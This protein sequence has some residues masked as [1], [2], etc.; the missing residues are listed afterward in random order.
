MTIVVLDTNVILAALISQK[1]SS[2]RLLELGASGKLEIFSSPELIAELMRVLLNELKSDRQEADAAVQKLLLFVK[3][4]VPKTRI[5]AVD[6][7]PDDNK[8]LECAASVDAEFVA[9]WDPDLLSLEK[10]GK[11]KITNPGK[12]LALLKKA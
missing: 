6:R 5:L 2:Y 3:I 7:D 9:S 11:I 10:F 4:T 1:G 8:V 12:L